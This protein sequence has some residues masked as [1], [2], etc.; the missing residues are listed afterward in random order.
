M[1]QYSYGTCP[2]SPG[3]WR[4][5]KWKYAFPPPRQCPDTCNHSENYELRPSTAGSQHQQC[6]EP[7]QDDMSGDTFDP[8][9]LHGPGRECQA[10]ARIPKQRPAIDYVAVG[11]GSD[12]QRQDQAD[13]AIDRKSVVYG[14]R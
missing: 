1:D 14:K 10:L 7:A 3:A 8:E 9:P 12:H 4:M 2:V 6:R 11:P 13:C 5:G